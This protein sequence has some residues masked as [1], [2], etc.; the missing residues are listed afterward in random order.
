MQTFINTLNMVRLL[1]APAKG[2]A[3]T[4]YL[5]FDPAGD[6]TTHDSYSYVC[7]CGRGGGGTTSLSHAKSEAAYHGCL[8]QR[9]KAKQ[10]A[11]VVVPELV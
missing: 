9:G 4:A 2:A 8:G 5:T 7:T 1:A 11:T 3:H 10:A 6:W